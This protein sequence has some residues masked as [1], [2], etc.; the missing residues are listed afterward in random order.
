[1]STT[2][3]KTKRLK[4]GAELQVTIEKFADRGKSVARL[5]GLVL[6]VRGAVP[7]DEAVVRIG[8]VKKRYVEGQ[9]VHIVRPS[10]LRTLPRCRYFGDCGGC[11][12]QNVEYGAQLDAKRQSVQEAFRH[13]G[14]FED[15][16]V[17]PVIGSASAYL[18]RNKMEFSFSA[19][20]WLT[21]TEIA[22][23]KTFE[24]DF[25]LGL[26]AP[27]QFAKVIDVEECHLQS[28]ASV[29]IVNAIRDLAIR[30][31][32]T[33][34]H[35]RTHKGLLRHLVIREG[36]RTSERMVNLVLSR[37]DQG[38]IEATAELLRQ[39]EFAVTT[40]VV[41]V[42][43]TPAQTSMGDSV[44]TVFGPGRIRE[45]LGKLTFHIGPQSFFQTNSEQAERLFETVRSLAEP[46]PAD[47]VYDLYCGAGTIGMYL[48]Q[49]V[50]RVVGIEVVAQA[51]TDAI[52]NAKENGVT[53]C[54]F[55]AGDIGKI[56]QA[57]FMEERGAPDLLIV[58]PPRA[59]L[60]PRVVKRIGAMRVPRFVYVSCNPQTQARDLRMISETYTIDRLQ[61]VD[62]FPQTEHIENVA[63]LTLRP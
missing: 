20:R 40:F 10:P 17:E 2:G 42:N 11:K 51:V 1:M 26:H 57:E 36:R 4:K 60:H 25:A 5:D 16:S 41:T 12:W 54:E 24:K 19:Q 56:L 47:V 18:Y 59:G 63:R 49:D 27:G 52:L 15:A 53:N 43:D 48:S 35:T 31:G 58:D 22:S 34:W 32:W 39:E 62:L 46:Q 3:A 37:A 29:S 50:T 7:G 61:P 13:T 45:R 21:A 23:D 33:A 14:G 30:R 8:R 6:F 28:A 9:V 44:R 55:V 38:V